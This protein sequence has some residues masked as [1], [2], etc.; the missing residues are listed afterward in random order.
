MTEPATSQSG[1]GDAAAELRDEPAEYP[2]VSRRPVFNGHV[3][4]VVSETVD[5][6]GSEL[7][8]DFI[9]HPGAVAVLALD[10][11][12]RVLLIKQYRHP[13]RARDWE[14]PAGLLD[15]DGE[16]PLAAAKRELAEEADLEA[17]EWNVLAEFW[18]SPGGSNEALRVYLAR[19]LSDLDAF[20]R[21]DEEADIEKR[22]VALDDALAAVLA[23][24]LQ[25]P[26]LAIGVLAAF[27]SRQGGWASL[28]DADEPWPRHPRIGHGDW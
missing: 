23:R 28:G 9:D 7:T 20:E 11:E 19:D 25:S 8:R 15:V 22:W 3:W 27:A 2:V 26:S 17:A 6:N 24:D 5:Y 18:T 16:P 21:F 14:I 12:G 10:D 1:P 13:V 4:D